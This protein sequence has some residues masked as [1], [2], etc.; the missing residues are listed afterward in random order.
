MGTAERAA[1][2]G[3][4]RSTRAGKEGAHGGTRGSP[5]SEPASAG[6]A[7]GQRTMKT[8]VPTST[9]LKS[10]SACGISMRMQPWDAE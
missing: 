5:V 8:G 1:G 4:I 7:S 9:W 3:H 2:S 10:H 6:D